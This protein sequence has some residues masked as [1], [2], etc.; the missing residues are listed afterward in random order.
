M[1]EKADCEALVEF[2]REVYALSS[3]PH[4]RARVTKRALRRA[5]ELVTIDH[6][7]APNL[8]PRAAQRH[9]KQL[10]L[11]KFRYCFRVCQ[12]TENKDTMP[13][14]L[15]QLNRKGDIDDVL[16]AL[17]FCLDVNLPGEYNKIMLL[18]QPRP[19]TATAADAT[20]HLGRFVSRLKTLLRSRNLEPV[21]AAKVFRTIVLLYAK[22][23]M[24]PRPPPITRAV[25]PPCAC[26]LATCT[27]VRSFLRE[28][29][30]REDSELK[31][32][33]SK[34]SVMK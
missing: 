21:S 27:T 2:A 18:F 19:L 22:V 20:T 13:A 8:D 16:A 5:A 26:P 12:E 17:E 25:V 24:G 31:R 1:E 7:P 23:I 29:F 11:D 32:S 28:K 9:S 15:A 6:P 34:S 30:G 14:F 4:T 3:V 33:P 10:K